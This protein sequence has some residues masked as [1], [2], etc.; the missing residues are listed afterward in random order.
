MTPKFSGQK[1]RIVIVAMPNALMLDVAGPADVFTM[2]NSILE[3]HPDKPFAGYE[4]L[5]V[6]P[7]PGKKSIA[8]SSGVSFCT[9]KNYRSVKGKT[10][11]I[12]LAGF[13]AKAY[14]PTKDFIRWLQTSAEKVRRIGSICKGAFLL[15]QA[16]LLNKRKA[17]TH[18]LFCKE[19]Q[20][21]YPQVK[22]DPDPIFVK[23]GNVYTSAGVS[24]GMDMALAMVEE[25]H[26]REVALSVARRLVLYLRRPGNQSQFSAVISE[27]EAEH[28][29]I[30]KLQSWLMEHL[31]E[32]LTVEQLAE[33][34]FM[35]TRNFAR[36]FSRET[37]TTPGKYIEKLRLEAA[38]RKLEETHLSLDE[39]ASK[40]GLG[41]ADSLRR[42]F[43]RHLKITPG[44]YRTSFRTALQHKGR[45][46]LK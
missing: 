25:D 33:K 31:K 42:L 9:D 46:A 10:D 24:S 21:S 19:L 35:S 1:K 26:G 44:H 30:R 34:C 12:L 41:S 3:S 40:C 16:D 13:S 17:T 22:V 39:I 7:D 15:A 37:G 38:R 29:P 45:V 5:V 11:T 32:A 23:D 28:E 36:V 2:A 18:W 4:V 6:S 8:T 14:T 43:I 27:Q 20:K